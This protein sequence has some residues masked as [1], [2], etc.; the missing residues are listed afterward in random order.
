MVGQLKRGVLRPVQGPPPALEYINVSTDTTAVLSCTAPPEKG[1]A[2]FSLVTLA[3]W[4][5]FTREI[6]HHWWIKD[7]RE[8]G[9]GSSEM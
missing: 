1:H 6:Q 4:P 3:A 9:E 8:E 7:F 2:P 5:I